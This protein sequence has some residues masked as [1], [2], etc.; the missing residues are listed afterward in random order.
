ME[1][2]I[3]SIVEGWEP[4]PTP[5]ETCAPKVTVAKRWTRAA[6]AADSTALYVFGDNDWRQG[7]GGQAVIRELPNAAGVPTIKR[8][9]YAA[10]DYYTDAELHANAA[11]IEAA[12]AAILERA[13]AYARVVFPRDGLGTGLADLP[14]RA[15][16]T[17]DRLRLTVLALA[18]AIEE[19]SSSRV[20]ADWPG[21]V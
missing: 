10:G 15:P 5:E 13:P 2:Y 1:E 18:E 11:Q 16:L 19:G 3:A 17:Y 8:P 21:R 12:C 20:A 7:K 9:G 6:V 14:R 4:E